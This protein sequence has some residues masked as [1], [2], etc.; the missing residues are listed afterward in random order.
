M[1][2]FS[3]EELPAKSKP[4]QILSDQATSMIRDIC[5]ELSMTLEA[6]HAALWVFH[7]NS[8]IVNYQN[9]DRYMY[10]CGAVLVG[11]KLT[12]CLRYPI[13]ILEVCRKILRKRKGLEDIDSEDYLKREVRKVFDA[14]VNI[15][16]N[17]GFDFDIHLALEE[18]DRLKIYQ[19]LAD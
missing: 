14:E 18:A 16:I 13:S 17:I 1:K 5:Q 12:E 9:F 6:L 15:M 4:Y 7:C 8:L 2:V 3:I 11:G 10:A 19:A